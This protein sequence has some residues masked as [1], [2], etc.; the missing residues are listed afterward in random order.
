M[1]GGRR[2][3]ALSIL[4]L[5]ITS[6]T[7]LGSEVYAQVKGKNEIKIGQPQIMWNGIVGKVT[8][9]VTHEVNSNHVWVSEG[10]EAK[11]LITIVGVVIDTQ[12]IF[13]QGGNFAGGPPVRGGPRTITY[14]F[15]VEDGWQIRFVAVMMCQEAKAGGSS[16]DLSAKSEFT[17]TK[18]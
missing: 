9:E 6:L 15:T 17:A 5:F 7:E 10:R 1:T 16:K 8:I 12:D 14:T 4:I 13:V 11:R 3:F 18:P 2:F